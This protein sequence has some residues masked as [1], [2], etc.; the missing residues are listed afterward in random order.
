MFVT[1]FTPTYNRAYTLGRLYDSIRRQKGCEFEW[2]IVDDGSIDNTE[3]LVRQ[4]MEQD[5]NPF[6]IRY[7]KQEN[8]GKHVAWNKGLHEAKGDIFLPVDSDDRLV[9][10][11][12]QSVLRMVGTVSPSDKII[13]VSG[14]RLFPGEKLTGGILQSRTSGYI[15]YSSIDRRSK[16]ISGDLAEAFFSERLRLYPFPSFVDEKFVPEAVIFN[17]FSNDGFK[18]RGFSDPLYCCEYL[19]DGYTRNVDALLVSNWKGYS[20]YIKELLRSPVSA[21]A[22]LIPLCGYVY[23]SLLKALHIVR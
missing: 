8:S 2:V 9:P 1:I 10:S 5:A 23:R 13:A 21:K 20:L 12:L 11:A 19:E 6:D 14:T 7:F 17:R 22:K 18:I 15:D 3:E 16:G 4:W